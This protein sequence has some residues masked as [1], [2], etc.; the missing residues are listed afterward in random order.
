MRCFAWLGVLFTLLAAYSL[1]F[2]TKYAMTGSYRYT[3]AGMFLA[4]FALHY[5]RQ[6]FKK[7]RDIRAEITHASLRNLRDQVLLEASMNPALNAD[8]KR[9]RA[10]GKVESQ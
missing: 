7:A 4:F 1:A 2:A 3:F 9:T 10:G 6:N 5:M 8:A